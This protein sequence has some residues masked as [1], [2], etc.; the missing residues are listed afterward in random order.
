MNT[1]GLVRPAIPQTDAYYIGDAGEL[2]Q[3]RISTCGPL[4][5][6]R[7]GGE[8]VEDELSLVATTQD[9]CQ[10]R[11]SGPRPTLMHVDGLHEAAATAGRMSLCPLFVVASI[12]I[13]TFCN[14]V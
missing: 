9:P 11:E 5:G 1:Y 4:N 12:A 6:S 13:A 2:Q 14:R 7:A 10:R 3:Q 8:W